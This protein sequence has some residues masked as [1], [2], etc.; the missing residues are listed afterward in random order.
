[1][2]D[3]V[4]TAARVAIIDVDKAEVYPVI[5][6]EAVTAGQTLY[7][8]STGKYGIADA[9]AAGKQQARGI[10][11]QAGGAG[12][13]VDLLKKGRV[14]GF[15][16]TSQAYDA[17]IFQSDTAGTLGDSA[18]TLSVNTGRVVPMSDSDLTKVLYADFDWLRTWA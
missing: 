7:L 5:L 1:M 15:T 9:N 17:P 6:A 11:L 16:L 10:A 12:Q 2:T 8:A 13:A 14:A 18:G 3:I 4:V